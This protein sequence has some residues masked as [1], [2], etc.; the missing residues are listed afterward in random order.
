M[1]DTIHDPFWGLDPVQCKTA[2]DKHDLL[3]ALGQ[4]YFNLLRLRAV[5]DHQHEAEKE[6]AELEK[7]VLGKVETKEAGNV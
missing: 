1:T 2:Q 5:A 4:A 7:K 6:L 3:Y